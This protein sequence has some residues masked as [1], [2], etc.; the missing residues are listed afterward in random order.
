[1]S[2]E[3]DRTILRELAKRQLEISQSIKNQERI[4]LWKA[5][6]AFQ[7]SAPVVHVEIDTFEQEILP[8]LL[9]CEGEEA[10]AAERELYRNFLNLELFDDD[11]VVPDYFP[12][13]QSGWFR[14][15]GYEITRTTAADS[16]G[17]RL[18]HRFHYVLADLH[19]DFEKLTPSE[20]GFDGAFYQRKERFAQEMFGDILP[21]RRT[22]NG[23]YAVPTQDVVHLMGMENMCF[24]LA[25]YPEEFREMMD[26]LAE[27]YLA[28]FHMLEK[29]G[30]LLPTAGFEKVAQGSLCFTE[31]LLRSGQ[32]ATRDVWGFL[33]SQE[34]VSIS[35]EMF[36]DF[37]F[38]CYRQIAS[39]YGKLSY[40][41][42]EPVHPVWEDLKTLPN[43]RKVS[44][45]PWG[46]EEYM[47]EQLRGAQIAY[48]RKPSPNFL[49]VGTILEEEEVRKHFR[50]T[51]RAASGCSLELIQRD[52]YTIN[53]DVGKVKR[54]VQLIREVMA[55]CYQP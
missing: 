12:V 20:F 46:D 5:H 44:V 28:Y 14:P 38:P 19:E 51:A 48:L 43:L 41:C 2:R 45:S 37:I 50:R 26:R 55:E 34:T 13:E 7:P 31:E 18:G 1:M 15:F 32:L 49:G 40:G 53:H 27:D 35:P 39:C 23:L 47:G 30:C 33:D 11:W 24:A 10:R 25:D 17:N 42:C 36:H 6:N 8:S 29:E 3:Q 4:L 16:A 22:M 9:R 54:Y 52:V 21:V